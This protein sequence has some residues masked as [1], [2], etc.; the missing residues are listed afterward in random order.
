MDEIKL[1]PEE[2]AVQEALKDV[3]D[4]ELMVNIVDLGLVYNIQKSNLTYQI[5]INL[6][7]TS[8]GCPLGDVIIQ[9]IENTLLRHFPAYTT[10]VQLVWM[11]PW[12]I[13]MASDEGRL[14][15]SEL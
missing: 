13:E 15:L 1:S 2:M 5:L 14:L 4:P 6:T 3:I 9:D 7:L 8:P 12:R 10:T 11:P